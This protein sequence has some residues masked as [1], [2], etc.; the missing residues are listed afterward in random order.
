MTNF[1][2]L[3]DSF[4]NINK[5]TNTETSDRKGRILSYVQY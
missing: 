5:A 1:Y 3:L 4:I 2:K